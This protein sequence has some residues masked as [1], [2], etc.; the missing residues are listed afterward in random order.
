MLV[1][2]ILAKY[3]QDVLL[4]LFSYVPDQLMDDVNQAWDIPA[5]LA[6]AAVLFIVIGCIIFP[7]GFFGCCGALKENKCMLGSVST[8]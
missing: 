7:I 6:E 3:Y 5:L 8:L 2:G 4:R 1:V